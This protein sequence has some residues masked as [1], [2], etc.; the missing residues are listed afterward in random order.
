MVFYRLKIALM[1]TKSDPLAVMISSLLE[2]FRQFP[3]LLI[4]NDQSKNCACAI[5]SPR[6]VKVDVSL[7][8]F[9]GFQVKETLLIIRLICERS[10][11]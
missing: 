8:C 5:E 11:M 1:A 4:I 3:C 10:F 6:T 7:K 9:L 2:N